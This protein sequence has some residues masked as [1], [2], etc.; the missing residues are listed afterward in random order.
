MGGTQVRNIL[1]IE[2]LAVEPLSEN[3]SIW[4]PARSSFQL[5][6]VARRSAGYH[7]LV[8]LLLGFLMR[9]SIIFWAICLT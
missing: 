9:S 8:L 1:L 7:W 4:G 3:F 5:V 6:E 2:L